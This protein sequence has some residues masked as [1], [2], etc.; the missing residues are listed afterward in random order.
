MD[1]NK[2]IRQ[3]AKAYD[4]KAKL[5]NKNFSKDLTTGLALFVEQ[6]KYIRDILILEYEEPEEEL[7]GDPFEEFLE[8]E[9]SDEVVDEAGAKLTSLIIAIE[10]F[11]S[12]IQKDDPA[13]KIFHWDNFWEFVK[14]NAEEWL[15]LYDPVQ[16]SNNS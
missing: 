2:A 6:L 10:E 13:Q 1:N 16:E 11:E 5:L 15:E 12:Y 3:L 8:D 7:P 4:K 14:L 9:D